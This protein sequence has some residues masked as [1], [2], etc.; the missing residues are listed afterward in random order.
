MRLSSIKN[1][2]NKL[3]FLP[4]NHLC[5][6]MLTS[7]I[8]KAMEGV[9][10]S[11]TLKLR[12]G[13]IIFTSPIGGANK[14]WD[15]LQNLHRFP[16]SSR[17]RLLI[18]LLQPET[19]IMR[20]TQKQHVQTAK[21][22]PIATVPDRNSMTDFFSTLFIFPYYLPLKTTWLVIPRVFAYV[23]Q[24]ECINIKTSMFSHLQYY[25]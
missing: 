7:W 19:E 13:Y 4:P 1:E 10:W 17:H 6:W 21:K 5:M 20:F 22:N 8:G 12:N 23:V 9:K 18:K 24:W 11:K 25:V 3:I 2:N 15:A 16:Y 14:K